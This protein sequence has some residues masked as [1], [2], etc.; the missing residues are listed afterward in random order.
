MKFPQQFLVLTG[1]K[2][3]FELLTVLIPRGDCRDALPFRPGVARSLRADVGRR[4][5]LVFLRGAGIR[6]RYLVMFV[7]VGLLLIRST[8]RVRQRGR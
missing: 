4:C 3:L 1:L 2:F 6:R 7:S 8:F 5:A